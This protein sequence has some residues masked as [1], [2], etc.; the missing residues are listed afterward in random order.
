MFHPHPI[1][2]AAKRGPRRA[3]AAAAA[4]DPFILRGSLREQPQDDVFEARCAFQPIVI[5]ASRPS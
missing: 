2:V 1:E 4:A 5:A 3:T